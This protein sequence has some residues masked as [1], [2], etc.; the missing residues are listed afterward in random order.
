LDFLNKIVS[1][2]D[3]IDIS[4]VKGYILRFKNTLIN[5]MEDTTKPK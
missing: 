5:K 3:Y 1:N 4:K 2:F